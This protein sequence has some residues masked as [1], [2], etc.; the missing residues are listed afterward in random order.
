MRLFGVPLSY[1]KAL[2]VRGL[3]YTLAAVNYHL[4]QGSLVYLL[5]RAS[6]K[7]LV[8]CSGAVMG[9][10]GVQ[11]MVLFIVA[12][13]GVVGDSSGALAPLR[14]YALAGALGIL[15]F[16]GILARPPAFL[17]SFRLTRPVVAA[18]PSG[19]LRAMAA[20]VPHTVVLF[21]LN[22]VVM[23]LFGIHPPL[24]EGLARL[25][26]VFFVVALPI[27]VQG[28]GTGQAAAAL[29]LA[30]YAEAGRPAVVAYSLSVWALAL[31]FQL[32]IGIPFLFLAATRGPGKAKAAASVDQDRVSP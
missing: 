20:R 26:A 21:G 19:M 2:K 3:S 7:D 29:L 11:F 10:M 1:R 27:S 4:G 28:L 30:P 6:G 25:S 16:F 9:A 14:P 13:A 12:L 24:G 17:E 18:G 22:W 23:A 8:V 5:S 31:L 15:V 32:A